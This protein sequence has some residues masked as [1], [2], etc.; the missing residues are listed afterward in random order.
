MRLNFPQGFAE[1]LKNLI[2]LESRGTIIFSK[3]I[4]H[5][6]WVRGKQSR[7]G[8]TWKSPLHIVIVI[9]SHSPPLV[10]RYYKPTDQQVMP[11]GSVV[12]R[13]TLFF[14]NFD[15]SFN[16]S[17]AEEFIPFLYLLG[18]P[19]AV[20]LSPPWCLTCSLGLQDVQW[21]VRLVVVRASWPGHPR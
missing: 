15:S 2:F 6:R 16:K 3:E 1:F 5:S 19:C 7:K 12:V 20:Y 18:P 8:K 11:R 14:L 13:A 4:R 17:G 21:A 9:V 10:P